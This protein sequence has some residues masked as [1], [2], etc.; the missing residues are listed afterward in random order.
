MPLPD[1]PVTLTVSEIEEL[2][3]KLS[4]ARHTVNNCLSMVS[5]AAELLRRK[6]EMAGRMADAI[7]EQPARIVEELRGF[8]EEFE[9]A[10]QIG[11][12]QS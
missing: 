12:E 11:P 5:A 2:N 8:T 7:S 3:R 9:R 10:L 1:H 6:P 4:A